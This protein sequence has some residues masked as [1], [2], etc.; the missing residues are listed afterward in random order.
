MKDLIFFHIAKTSGTSIKSMIKRSESELKCFSVRHERA[1]FYKN[2]LG[3]R[4]DDFTKF[5]VVRNPYTRFRS[6]CRQIM[7]NPNRGPKHIDRVIMSSEMASKVLCRQSAFLSVDGEIAADKIFRFEEDVP[8]GVQ[9]WLIEMG[10]TGEMPHKRE[11]TSEAIELN[12]EMIEF[13]RGYYAADFEAFG[14][15]PDDISVL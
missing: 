11:A 1:Q 6:G 3:D 4:F 15:D 10:A 8:A 2:H 7:L 12:E 14:Y 13:V 5:T 9:E